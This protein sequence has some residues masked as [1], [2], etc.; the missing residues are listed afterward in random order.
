MNLTDQEILIITE[1]VDGS[2]SNEN[3]IAA[4]ELIKT[5][6]AAERFENELRTSR[7]PLYPKLILKRIQMP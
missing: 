5:N 1:Y 3:I 7:L 6:A 4:K 2:P